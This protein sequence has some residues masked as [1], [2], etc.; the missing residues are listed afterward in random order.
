MIAGS[1]GG[2]AVAAVAFAIFILAGGQERSVSTVASVTT[3]VVASTDPSRVDELSPRAIYEADAPGVVF[4]NAAGETQSPSAAEYLKGEGPSGPAVAT[5]SGFEVDGRGTLVTNWHVVQGASRITVGLA[6][7]SSVQASLIGSDPSHDIAV[8]RIPTGGV[9]LHPLSLGRSS[10]VHVG[11]PAYA[12]GNPFGLAR[13][14]T[15]GVIS[16]LGRRITAPDGVAIGSAMQTD[17]P[18]NP[19]NSGGP[20]LNEHGQVVGINAQIETSGSGGGSVG[21]AFA[22]PIETAEQELAKLAKR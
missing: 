16:A 4:V 6:P 15:T 3:R 1:I 10:T 11:D 9:V 13:T 20:L 12:I 18:I 2:A 19:G 21:I 8:L 7:G 5:G 17:A 14:L 22:I